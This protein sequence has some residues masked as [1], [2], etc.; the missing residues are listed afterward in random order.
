M[1]SFLRPV[2]ACHQENESEKRAQGHH[3]EKEGLIVEVIGFKG[4][5]D[6]HLVSNITEDL[7]WNSV[8]E[9]IE[10]G[11]VVENNEDVI[12]HLIF[13]EENF[14]ARTPLLS[15]FEYH[16]IFKNEITLLRVSMGQI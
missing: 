12:M 5:C 11:G 3:E 6:W 14:I 13:R 15:W 10:P 2:H 4:G 9:L 8:A 1:G 16:A 7:L